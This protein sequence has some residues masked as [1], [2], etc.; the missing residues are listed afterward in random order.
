MPLNNL[1]HSNI[2][3]EIDGRSPSPLPEELLDVPLMDAS[4]L[5]ELDENLEP[6]Q[7]S[8]IQIAPLVPKCDTCGISGWRIRVC[9]PCFHKICQKCFTEMMI[10]GFAGGIRF[11]MSLGMCT[12]VVG[13]TRTGRYLMKCCTDITHLL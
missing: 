4:W 6:P 5:S 11:T 12:V 10:K 1:H 7:S 8:P 2:P 9:E 3:G 13:R